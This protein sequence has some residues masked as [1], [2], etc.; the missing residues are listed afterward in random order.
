MMNTKLVIIILV[1]VM[2]VLGC[3]N[4]TVTDKQQE[5]IL[6]ECH[7]DNCTILGYNMTC[8]L[9]VVIDFNKHITEEY[10][11]INQCDCLISAGLANCFPPDVKFHKLNGKEHP[12]FIYECA[13]VIDKVL[14][15]N[16]E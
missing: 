5:I 12:V 6:V 2:F 9:C 3:A 10:I 4:N 7:R 16:H 11:C 15:K 13:S 1:A 8:N 14:V